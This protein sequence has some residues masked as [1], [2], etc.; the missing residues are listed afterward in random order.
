MCVCVI[1]FISSESYCFIGVIHNSDGGGGRSFTLRSFRERGSKKKILS[2]IIC[3]VGTD[4][5]FF[6]FFFFIAIVERVFLC[7]F[8]FFCYSCFHKK[9]RLKCIEGYQAGGRGNSGEA[10]ISD[11]ICN[12][13]A[14]PPPPTPPIYSSHRWAVDLRTRTQLTLCYIPLP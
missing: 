2:V 10:V 6:F 12:E 14:R 11:W 9:K 13:N 1:N 8:V 7:V 4:F 3:F 5:T